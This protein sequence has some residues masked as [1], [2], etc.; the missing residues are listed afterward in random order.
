MSIA[1]QIAGYVDR[2]I[3]ETKAL[4]DLYRFVILSVNF[5]VGPAALIELYKAGQIRRK[6][7]VR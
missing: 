5:V 7:I 4:D 1:V 3:L 2:S 6:G